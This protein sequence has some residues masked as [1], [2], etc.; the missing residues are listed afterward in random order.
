MQAAAPARM[1]SN[2]YSWAGFVALAFGVLGLLA[3]FATYA[4][5]V[6]LERALARGSVLDEVLVA[7]QRGADLRTFHDRLG[8]SA[9]AVLNGPG[10]LPERIRRERAAIY[11]RLSAEAAGLARRLRLM[12]VIM[13]IM[14]IAFGAAVVAGLSGGAE[15]RR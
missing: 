4:V 9:D 2:R 12:I 8:D 7:G 3:V 5:P 14:C 11:G 6:P 13:T 1:S 10:S 15:T